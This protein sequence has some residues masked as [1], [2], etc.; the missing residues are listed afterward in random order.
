METRVELLK[1]EVKE[2]LS[3]GLAQVISYLFIAFIAA[4][5]VIFVSIAFA[6]LL[7]ERLGN[8]AGF[9]IIAIVYFVIGV[10]L[11][12]KRAK[13]IARLERKLSLLLKKKNSSL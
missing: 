1:I 5:V 6:L 9:S 3:K 11:W 2:E 13:I 7:G 8:P 12:Y 10:V 4:V